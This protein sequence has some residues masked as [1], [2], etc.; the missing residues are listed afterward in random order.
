MNRARPDIAR[1][2]GHLSAPDL[3]YVEV[4]ADERAALARGG[5]PVVAARTPPRPSRERPGRWTVAVTPAGPGAGATTVAALLRG[6]VVRQ[7][8]LGPVF[9]DLSA[10]TAPARAAARPADEVLLVLRADGSALGRVDAV[11]RQLAG[12]RSG[13]PARWVLNAFDEADPAQRS[14]AL[15]LRGVLGARLAVLHR[16]DHLA[17]A[18]RAADADEDGLDDSQLWADGEEIAAELLDRPLGKGD[19]R[20][21]R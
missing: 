19:E 20:W 11:E 8:A 16:D 21:R 3:P 2:L 15:A 6:I 7:R 14:T 18:L 4:R 9:L 12:V 10:A 5:G 13:A 17:A 1:L